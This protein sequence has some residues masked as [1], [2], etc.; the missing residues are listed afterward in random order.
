MAERIE[1]VISGDAKALISEL[2]KAG[3][4]VVEFSDKADKAGKGSKAFGGEV[5]NLAAELGLMYGLNEVVGMIK[6]FGVQSVAAAKESAAAE[7]QLEAVLKSTRQ[8]AG[9]TK[10]ELTAMASALQETTNFSDEA[11]IQG[12]SLLLTFTRIGKEV[13]PEATQ[14]MLDMSQAMGQDVKSSAIQLGKA[15]NDP[16]E[17]LSALTR[18]GVTFTQQQQDQIKAMVEAGNLAGAQRAILAELNTEFGGSA[19]AAREAAGGTQDLAVAYGD[20]QEAVGGLLLTLGDSGAT[21]ALVGVFEDLT[22]GAEAWQGVIKDMNTINQA[23]EKAL[24]KLGMT[25]VEYNMA[26]RTGYLDQGAYNKALQEAGTAMAEQEENQRRAA[27]ALEMYAAMQEDAKRVEEE[28]NQ[29]IV[30]GFTPANDL[31]NVIGGL[32]VNED[33][34]KQATEAYAEAQRKTQ[35]VEQQRIETATGLATTM[36]DFFNSLDESQT[37]AAEKQASFAAQ[38]TGMREDAAE[39]VKENEQKLSDDLTKIEQERQEKIAWV[40]SGGHART[41]AENDAALGYWNAHYDKLTAD[42]TAKYGEQNTAIQAA[43][44]ERE[45]QAA[46]AREKEQAAQQEHL[47][48]LKLQAALATLETTG[49]LEQF[50]GGLAVSAGEAAELIKAGVLPV[51]EEFGVAIQSVLTTLNEKQVEASTVATVNQGILQAAY[52]GTLEPMNQQNT[53]LAETM[54]ASAATNTEAMLAMNTEM[55]TGFGTTTTTATTTNQTIDNIGTKTLPALQS[56]GQTTTSAL[57]SG[58]QQTGSAGRTAGESIRSGM[59][60]ALDKI[61]DLENFVEG[62]VVRAFEKMEAAAKRAAE[63]AKS[64]GS[65]SSS[66][67]APGF[68]AG[69]PST[70]FLVPGMAGQAYPITVHGGERV[71][72]ETA[73][74]VREG[75]GGGGG[76]HYHYHLN[77]SSMM[78]SAGLEQDFRMIQTAARA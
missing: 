26:V 71:Y 64:A 53:L 39:S 12:E 5:K 41:Q 73:G 76:D 22:A 57:V 28:R 30:E 32:A 13:F 58:F 6:D 4:E 20:L 29:A 46:A 11:V 7:K 55:Q 60:R 65:S 36:G 67:G 24:E 23:H 48:Q 2:K 52:A 74:S 38:M 8:A 21:D 45:T 15:L 40:L 62:P 50:T 10:E 33:L 56:Q 16:V 72:V 3:V 66:A 68:A 18:V 31:S 27:G 44:A 42:T 17:G 35:E 59:E 43:L 69:T 9:V 54:P 70:G 25:Q 75:R 78:P 51:T 1:I 34:A 47:N 77:V 63:A 14:T 37:S 19:A 49:Q 61:R